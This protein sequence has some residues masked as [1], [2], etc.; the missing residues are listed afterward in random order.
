MVVEPATGVM[1]KRRAFTLVELLIIVAIIVVISAALFPVVGTSR[2][3]AKQADS[4]SHMEQIVVASALYASD[5][6]GHFVLSTQDLDDNQCGSPNASATSGCIEGLPTPTLNWPVLLL[7]YIKTVGLFVDPGTGDPQG[8]F[9]QGPNATV[10]NWNNFAQYGYNY[11]FLSPLGFQDVGGNLIASGL[12]RSYSSAVHPEATVMFTTAQ[13]WATLSSGAAQFA[14][15]DY[16]LADAPGTLAF[17]VPAPDRLVVISSTCFSGTD[18]FWTCSWLKNSPIGELTSDVRALSPY[19]GANVAWVDGHVSNMT[20]DE[21]AV[22]TD[23]ETATNT[24]NPTNYGAAGSIV[25]NLTT[26][27]W[28]LDGTLNDVK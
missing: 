26:Y 25:T 20:A 28:S 22:G 27:L 1:L 7:P 17:L 15:P 5:A 10:Q 3:A 18:T 14:T 4:L 8:Y 2:T 19:N 11:Q 24:S 23:F 13:S 16:E 12:S 9:G 21:L 6:E